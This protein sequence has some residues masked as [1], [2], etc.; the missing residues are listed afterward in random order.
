MGLALVVL[1]V[2]MGF[3][4]LSG[5][6]KLQANIEA[7]QAGRLA[8]ETLRSQLQR[9]AAVSEAIYF[10]TATCGSTP[11][12]CDAIRFAT[13]T[14][15]KQTWTFFGYYADPAKD[16]VYRCTY[17]SA[18]ATTCSSSVAL[19]G[20]VTFRA[21][22]VS[23]PA[24]AHNYGITASDISDRTTALGYTADPNV[25]GSNR[26]FVVQF[27]T[28]Q[29]AEEVHLLANQTPARVSVLHALLAPAART[30]YITWQETTSTPLLFTAPTAAAQNTVVWEDRYNGSYQVAQAATGAW[31]PATPATTYA[32]TSGGTT[33]ATQNFLS[34]QNDPGDVAEQPNSNTVNVLSI[35]VTPNAANLNGGLCSVFFTPAAAN[36]NEQGRYDTENI[37]VM[38]AFTVTPTTMTL[39]LSGPGQVN[40]TSA[41]GSGSK[42]WDQYAIGLTFS[43]CPSNIVSVS[44]GTA[45]YPAT[46]STTASSTPFT[47]T[48]VGP[49]S[50]TLTVTDQYG[51]SQTIGIAVGNNPVYSIGMSPATQTVQAP[52]NAAV[53]IASPLANGAN[54]VYGNPNVVRGNPP[55]SLTVEITGVSGAG[56]SGAYSPTGFQPSDTVFTIGTS[57]VGGNCTV[58]GQDSSGQTDTSTITVEPVAPPSPISSP[59]PAIATPIPEACLGSGTTT[60]TMGPSGGTC[61]LSGTV[62]MSGSSTY[63]VTI[64]ES[65]RG[66]SISQTETDTSGVSTLTLEEA[67]N[68]DGGSGWY[69][70]VTSKN[71]ASAFVGCQGLAVNFT[72]LPS[73]SLP[74]NVTFAFSGLNETGNC[75]TVGVSMNFET[76]DLHAQAVAVAQENPETAVPA[77]LTADVKS[78]NANGYLTDYDSNDIAEKQDIISWVGQIANLGASCSSSATLTYTV[79]VTQ[80]SGSGG[81][82]YDNGHSSGHGETSSSGLDYVSGRIG[83]QT[84]GYGL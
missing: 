30:S 51:E 82:F 54:N 11:T 74:V 7:G 46:P 69:C 24:L 27:A 44:A 80:G 19:A 59:S 34:L 29:A 58:S 23:A 49:G 73:A 72:T 63:C 10:P 28:A 79:T 22:V 31:T 45:S 17:A 70:Y 13:E 60:F 12:S 40:P 64:S 52:K 47:V 65:C 48:A 68:S 77:S 38:G 43:G 84:N 5:S 15:D 71:L 67:N 4:A 32:C 36:A 83:M 37:Q 25:V 2:A 41:S 9:D 57:T 78:L 56:C 33:I 20:A 6:T 3:H 62:S 8:V 76:A 16:V 61:T 81:L 1:A 21:T 75:A 39:G 53:Q 50:C 26:V 18:E 14:P 66:D 42:M 55:T 35:A